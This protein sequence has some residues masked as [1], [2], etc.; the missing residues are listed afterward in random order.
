[1]RALASTRRFDAGLEIILRSQG[2]IAGSRS[3]S[4]ACSSRHA[5]RANSSEPTPQ[6]AAF[7]ISLGKRF[8]HL[9]GENRGIPRSN[10][11]A[12]PN[13]QWQER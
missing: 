5:S 7:A 11:L 4:M 10:A 12:E 9:E 2:L 6:D 13:L 1:M 8:F 3:A